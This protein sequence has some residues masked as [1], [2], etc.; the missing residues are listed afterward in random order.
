MGV[1]IE[2]TVSAKLQAM[3]NR[4]GDLSPLMTMLGR[5][6]Q[7][8]VRQNFN[9]GGRPEWDAIKGVIVLPKGGR[10]RK[11]RV[12]GRT[13][14]GGPLVVT[15]DLRGSIGFTPEAKDLVLWARPDQDPVKAF[16]HQYGTTIAGKNHNITIPARP[17]LVFQS[18]DIDWFRK[19]CAG[20]V[21]VGGGM[22]S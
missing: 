20:W 9:V 5:H 10:S 12:Q 21:R 6:M 18:E 8:S 16:V 19:A 17:Y 2:N 14:M 4:V 3:M 22:L 13:R 15:G 11:V 7:T 1:T